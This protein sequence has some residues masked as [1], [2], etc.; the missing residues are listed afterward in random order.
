MMERNKPKIDAQAGQASPFGVVISENDKATL[1]MVRQAIDAKRLRLAYQPVVLARDPTRIAFN[2]GLMR[3]L[4][5][6]GRIIPAKDFMGAVESHEIGREIDCAALEIGM[7]A[8]ARHRIA[9]GADPA[10][11]A[12]RT[13]RL[14]SARAAAFGVDPPARA[15][16]P[17]H[18]QGL[19][20]LPAAARFPARRRGQ[21]G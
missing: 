4:E 7:A 12:D 18:L 20:A 21:T 5:P 13:A 11:P 8:L 19:R 1:S 6:S 2:E 3:V 9:R 10:V 15:C 17:G 14:A 16:P